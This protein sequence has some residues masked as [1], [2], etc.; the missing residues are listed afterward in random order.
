MFLEEVLRTADGFTSEEMDGVSSR[1][2]PADPATDEILNYELNDSVKR[3]VCVG[4]KIYR[5]MNEVI[6]GAQKF[7]LKNPNGDLPEEI[8][9]RVTSLSEQ[10]DCVTNIFWAEIHNEFP[11]LR[12]KDDGALFI[13]Q[14]WKICWRGSTKKSGKKNAGPVVIMGCK[15]GHS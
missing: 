13:G 12:E 1:L 15:E 9:I 11:E 8:S 2:Q 3:L 6:R 14:G 4:E 7:L 10:H 5:E